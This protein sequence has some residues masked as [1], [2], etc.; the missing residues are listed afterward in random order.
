MRSDLRNGDLS[1]E[2]AVRFFGRSQAEGSIGKEVLLPGKGLPGG[3]TVP[4]RPRAQSDRDLASYRGGAGD[5]RAS[6]PSGA[7]AA[8][9]QTRTDHRTTF[10]AEQTTRRISALDSARC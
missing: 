6:G 9:S 3:P 1:T 7:T 8:I 10:R 5:A 2:A 4:G